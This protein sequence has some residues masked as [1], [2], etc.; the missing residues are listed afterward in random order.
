LNIR[1]ELASSEYASN[2]TV[3]VTTSGPLTWNADALI[4]AAET[5]MWMVFLSVPEMTDPSPF[6]SMAVVVPAL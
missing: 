3:P 1:G 4:F 2:S 5:M 6:S